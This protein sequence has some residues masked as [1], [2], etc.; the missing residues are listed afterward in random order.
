[1][2][3]IPKTQTTAATSSGSVDA[4][5]N[6]SNNSSGVGGTG[7]KGK[8]ATTKTG[9][10]SYGSSNNRVPRSTQALKDEAANIGENY[11]GVLPDIK[12]NLQM[13]APGK[14]SLQSGKFLHVY[15]RE[16]ERKRERL[17]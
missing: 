6:S 4:A 5:G 9:G 7:V 11:G 15:E 2:P 1:M 17:G 13:I 14:P 12:Y 16:R 10:V 3:I 8:G